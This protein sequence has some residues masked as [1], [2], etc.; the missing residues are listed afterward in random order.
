M[1][2]QE[3]SVF[4]CLI[5]GRSSSHNWLRMEHSTWNS[6]WCLSGYHMENLV[7]NVCQYKPF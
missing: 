7:V 5:F 6:V 1:P 2:S 3:Y 4:F